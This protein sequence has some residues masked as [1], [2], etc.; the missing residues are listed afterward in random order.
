MLSIRWITLI[1]LS[2]SA[3]G[4]ATFGTVVN[5]TGGASDIILDEPRGRL[6][7]VRPSPYNF[8]DIYSI[9]QRRVINS[10]RTDA[11]PLA[12]ALSRDGKL[13]YVTCHDSSSIVAID[14]DAQVLKSRVSLPAKPEGI[15]VGA[16]GRVL[17]TT[18]GT[19]ANNLLDTL[20][21][22]DPSATDASKQLSVVAVAPP[23]PQSPILPPV[24][25]RVFLSMRS[26]L[27]ATR[28]GKRII[29]INAYANTNRA[30]FVYEVNS[31]T[32]LKSRLIVGDQ[33]T[34]LS[35]SPDGSKFMA[36]L[37]LFETESLTVL[38]QMNA[39]NAPFPLSATT[40][41]QG[42][43][44]VATQFN[45]QQNQGGS[46]F[47]PTGAN[48]YAAFN[49]A[50]IQSPPARANIAQMMI[51]DPEN[52]LINLGIQLVENLAGKMVINSDGAN[53]YGLSESGFMILPMS[54]L[55][56]NPIL[57]PSNTAL[58]LGND[59]C[60]VISDA[61]RATVAINNSQRG[62]PNRNVQAT[63]TLLSSLAA[64]NVPGLGGFGGAGG[65]FP[66][67]G[68]IINLPGV[69]GAGFPGILPAGQT[70]QQAQITQI[71]PS[72]QIVRDNASGATGFQFSFSG[73]AAR[74][75]GTTP[76]SDFIVSSDQA[77]NIPPSI[78]VYQNNRDSESRGSILP[79]PVGLSPNEG[80]ID[81]VY[82]S[83]RQRLYISNSGLNR[84]EVFDIRSNRLL[85][86]IKV[87]QLPHTLAL[88]SDNNTLYVANTGGESIS[89]VDLD[90]GKVID[91]IRFPALP[92][93]GSAAIISPSVIAYSQRGLQIVMS[94][95]ALWKV[96]GKDAVPR[97]VSPIIGS[98]TIPAPRTMASTP[99]GEFIL[100]LDGNGNANLYD[101]VVDDYVQRRQVQ[102]AP[103]QGY[104]GPVS[105]GPR[106]QYFL[107][108]G[109]VLNQ[110]LSPIATAG[111][112][113][114]SQGAGGFGAV[115]GRGGTVQTLARPVPAVFAS[116]TNSFARF[117]TPVAANNN[118]VNTTAP[119]LEI[120][121]VNTGIAT[122]SAPALEGPVSSVTGTQRANVAGRT[123]AVDSTAAN[124]YI[125]TTSGLSIVPLDVIPPNARPVVPQNSIVSTAS[126]LPKLAQGS[127]ASIFGRNLASSANANPASN[128]PTFIGGVCVT[129][130][131][132]PLPLIMTSNGQI[133]VQVPPELAPG[134]YPLVVRS[135][136]RKA[137]SNQMALTIVKYAPAV[138]VD[139]ASG[140]ASVFHL[141]GKPV[142]KDNPAV[143][144]ED[145][146]I[147]ATGLGLPPGTTK[148][149]SGVA[150]TKPLA[151]V[152]VKVYFGD[153][154]YKEAEMIVE[155][156][157]VLPGTVGQYLILVRVPGAHL[158]GDALRVTIRA[159]GVDSPSTGP[160]IPAISVQ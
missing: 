68:V 61:R 88:T 148:L 28:D 57:V 154:R 104:Y 95:G 35:V 77:V 117:T 45:T 149:I 151:T 128:L 59:Q 73:M 72:A 126:Y 4:A 98:A 152:G 85:T 147:V 22:F 25:G 108:N 31:G 23:P 146:Q 7:L 32:V 123:M 19:G 38:A 89:I 34:V 40:T 1:S 56:D 157:T 42:F 65:G 138:F 105:A 75:I 10:I 66:G 78:R 132:L 15:A 106:G 3:L 144:D 90:L 12:A 50:P 6:Y 150:P 52:L 54:T 60:G 46:V 139:P 20:M 63:P 87:G 100:L 96:V 125:L 58:L 26:Q 137:A 53:V 119:Q 158:R 122:L 81:L 37:R 51:S 124:A 142:T 55:Q 101:A 48:I 18:I 92:F 36:G 155:S 2:L 17:L 114:V 67:G 143:R 116:G 8:I 64:T 136:D 80:L 41:A 24:A 110:T 131:N 140:Q 33:S 120:V 127:L 21:V 44:Q 13:L 156:S 39:A 83:S 86:P 27:I 112:T 121:D 129:L 14:V 99:N 159:N 5:I 97:A 29:G 9:P 130:N 115:P 76:A 102:P 69:P 134:T 82:D 11:Q 93:N 118:Q 43:T 103:I 47:A 49:V 71:A 79:I 16:D 111:T 70:Q 91:N 135:V 145:I 113:Q 107:V 30:L 74:S 153:P 109:W 84:V 160:S 94:N 62:A 141:D 133:N